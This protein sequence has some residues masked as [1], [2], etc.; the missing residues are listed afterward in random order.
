[1]IRFGKAISHIESS[2]K[3]LLVPGMLFQKLGFRYFGPIN[4]HDIPLLIRTFQKIQSLNGPVLLHI[5]TIKGKGYQ[6]AEGNPTKYHGVGK[7]DKVTGEMDKKSGGLPSYTQVFSDTIVELG[8]KDKRVVA[9]TAAMA[10]GTGLVDFS[11]AYPDRF[12]DVGIAEGHAGTFAAGLAAGG[13]RPYL[14]IYS[15]FMQRA[16]DMVAHDMALQK[17]P[18]VICMDRAG[19]VGNDG[20]THHGVFDLTYMSTLPDLVVAVPKDGNELRSMLH[21]T[22]ENDLDGPVSIRYPRA[23]VPT[24]MSVDILP[25]EWG[26]W[27]YLTDKSEFVI[28]ATGTMVSTALEAAEWLNNDGIKICV[29]NARFVKPLDENVLETVCSE[30]KTVVTIE[31]NALR[32]GFGQAVAEYLITR[33]FSGKFRAMGIKDSFITHGDRSDLLKE[34]GLDLDS[35]CDMLSKLVREKGGTTKETNGLFKKLRLRK[36]GVARKKMEEPDSNVVGAHKSR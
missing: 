3:G 4:G 17:L 20:P 30:A 19:L 5:G 27:E 33:Q 21:W 11:K 28:L 15:T 2:I 31:E 9:I 10:P 36:N 26:Q 18:V 14:T 22:V 24:K 16:F 6:P 29:V 34:T 1:V 35:V 32:G 23:S 25:I 13:A 7:F 12:Y 8:A